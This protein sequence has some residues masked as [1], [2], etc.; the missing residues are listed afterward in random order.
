MKT[1][2]SLITLCC[3]GVAQTALATPV[4]TPVSQSRSVSTFAQAPGGGIISDTKSAPDFGPFVAGSGSGAF[5]HFGYGVAAYAVQ[6]SVTTP[7]GVD[8]YGYTGGWLDGRD[9]GVALSAL[10]SFAFEFEL[11]EQAR[12]LVKATVISGGFGNGQLN[13][14]QF[15]S[16][17]GPSGIIFDWP[18]N[19]FSAYALNQ[20][21]DAG[22][23]TIRAKSS[24]EGVMVGP[25]YAGT[26]LNRYR[27]FASVL[28]PVNTPDSGL[29]LLSSAL[30]LCLA[31]WG[32]RRQ[33]HAAA[34]TPGAAIAAR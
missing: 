17:T 34:V 23:Y 28:S 19:Y 9:G 1:A 5:G 24:I 30:L 18:Q 14:K 8:A 13:D 21:L 12:V 32:K 27:M 29:G 26:I 6:S 2:I 4:L 22:V 25:G 33:P 3:A 15:V 10:S 31:G 16:L 11:K 20:I 7:S